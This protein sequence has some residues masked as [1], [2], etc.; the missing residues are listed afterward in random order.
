MAQASSWLQQLINSLKSW[1]LVF[2]KGPGFKLPFSY[3][4]RASGGWLVVLLGIIAMLFWNWQLL[5]ATGAGVLVMALV[6]LMQEWNW[7][8]HLANLR[9]LVAGSNRQL[10]LAVA[11]GGMATLTSYM[12]VSVWIDSDSAWISAGAILQGFGTLATF[13]LL[14]W[15]LLYSQSSQEQA[16]GEQMLNEL[17]DADPVKRLLAVRQ[18]THWGTKPHLQPS[19]RRVV[20]DCFRLMLS[21]EQ[22]SIIREAVLNG[23]NVLDSNQKFAKAVQ[24]LQTPITLKPTNQVYEPIEQVN[25]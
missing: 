1:L 3:R 12:A 16:K 8:L 20:A 2:V 24:P 25:R 11:S 5:L 23:L 13:S 10:A 19:K 6:Y 21:H 17:T 7:Q 22:E 15:Q 18:L 14:V 4:F 9:R